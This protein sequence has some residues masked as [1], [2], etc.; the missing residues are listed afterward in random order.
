MAPGVEE[1]VC[2][3][4]PPPPLL[5]PQGYVPPPGRRPGPRPTGAHLEQPGVETLGDRT[6]TG[7]RELPTDEGDLG[8]KLLLTPHSPQGPGQMP[9]LALCHQLNQLMQVSR[10]AVESMVSF[11][12]SGKFLSLA[13][14]GKVSYF[15]CNQFYDSSQK[16]PWFVSVSDI[17]ISY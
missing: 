5:Q 6:D 12:M 7:D 3:S 15:S 4:L 11:D 13:S 2:R 10:A 8:G 17:V 16:N 9:S 14:T 1:P